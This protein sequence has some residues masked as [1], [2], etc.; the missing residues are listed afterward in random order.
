MRLELGTFRL[1]RNDIL[2]LRQSIRGI[3]V[4]FSHCKRRVKIEQ[5]FGDKTVHF[6]RDYKS[7][8]NYC[9][10]Y[11]RAFELC[12]RNTC[13]RKEASLFWCT[14]A[15]CIQKTESIIPS[16]LIEMWNCHERTTDELPRTNNSVEGSQT[17]FVVVVNGS[18]HVHIIFQ[19]TRA[20]MRKD[21]NICIRWEQLITD[22]PANKRR[23]YVLFG[24]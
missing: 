5:V 19:L 7:L 10:L 15:L 12:F 4:L 21:V 24:L 6:H 8:I 22:E 18:V 3:L 17:G 11:F 2:P 9:T 1:H 20:L 23:K 16:C 14:V 13:S